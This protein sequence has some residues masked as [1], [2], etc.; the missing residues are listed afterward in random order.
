MVNGTKVTKRKASID[1]F[2][3]LESE[4]GSKIGKRSFF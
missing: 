1:N 4:K 2:L 3:A